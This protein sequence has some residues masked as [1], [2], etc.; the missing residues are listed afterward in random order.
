[1]SHI[2]VKPDMS[3]HII[4]LSKLK[5]KCPLKPRSG[6]IVSVF[7]YAALPSWTTVYYST[8]GCEA[9]Q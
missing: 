8:I 3:S 2:S 6:S 7:E 5:H 1:M 9:A 4:K